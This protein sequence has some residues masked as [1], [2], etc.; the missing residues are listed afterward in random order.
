MKIIADEEFLDRTEAGNFI[1]MATSTFDKLLAK[2]RH[3]KLVYPLEVYQPG[4]RGTPMWFSKSR[5]KEWLNN[6]ISSGGIARLGKIYCFALLL[7]ILSP[8]VLLND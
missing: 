6:V 8:K 5:L 7:R 4:G 3:G 2:S 1:G